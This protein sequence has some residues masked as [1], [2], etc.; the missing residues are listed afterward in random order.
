MLETVESGRY[1]VL[2]FNALTMNLNRKFELF[3]RY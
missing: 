2:V 3:L 1:M